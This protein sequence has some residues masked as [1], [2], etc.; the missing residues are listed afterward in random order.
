MD[1]SAANTDLWK[2]ITQ[3]G[4]LC[5]LLLIGN[6]LRRKI[7]V[8]GKSLLPTAVIGGFVGLLLRQIGWFPLDNTFLESVNY[9][10]IAI[11]FIALGLRI[12]RRA[13]GHR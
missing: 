12:P 11:G 5:V 2:I 10:M 1:F 13:K 6:V 7:P 9:H 4:L 8:L 3:G